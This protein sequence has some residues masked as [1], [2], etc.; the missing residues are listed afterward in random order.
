MFTV[1]ITTHNR[2][3]LLQRALTALANQSYQNFS[4]L[5][6]SDSDTYLPPYPH[7]QA[8][9]GPYQYVLRNGASGPAHSRNLAIKLVDTDYAIFL[10]DDDTFEPNHLADLAA[11]LQGQAIDQQVL[12]F[13]DFNIIEEDRNQNPPVQLKRYS[14]TIAGA[15]RAMMFVKNSIPN[16]CL[17][18]PRQLLQ[19]FAFDPGL[20]LF[21]DWEYLL[22]C[23]GRAQLK[24]LAIESANIHKSFV[25]GE[26]NIRRG[27]VNDEFLVATTLD[28]YRRHPAPD[29]ITRRERTARFASLGISLEES[30]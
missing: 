15:T 1:I 13:H 18:Y 25:G 19:A 12:Y 6:I 21:E 23:L 4:T 17:I 5:V 24:H 16:N 3:L 14:V 29:E 7:L 30:I 22:A 10:D 20:I 11:A 8:L 28:I 2:P 9:P 27:N 26:S